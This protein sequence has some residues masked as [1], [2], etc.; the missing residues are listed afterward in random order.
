MSPGSFI[1]RAGSP[2]AGS[3]REPVDLPKAGA[4]PCTSLIT[5]GTSAPP[6]SA[7]AVRHYVGQ[8]ER[9]LR[10]HRGRP[11]GHHVTSF[12]TN[13]GIHRLSRPVMRSMQSSILC[14]N[15]G[16]CQIMYSGKILKGLT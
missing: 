9:D 11:A 7:P 1:S 5:I 16:S 13:A 15:A 6:L 12:S 14:R 4:C 2:A 3:S 10:D 8:E